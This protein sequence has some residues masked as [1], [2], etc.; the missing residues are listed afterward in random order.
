MTWHSHQLELHIGDSDLRK[1]AIEGPPDGQGNENA[2]GAL[3]EQGLPK[4]EVAIAEDVIGANEDQT[5]G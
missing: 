5:Q 3:D 4:N 2:V 1:G